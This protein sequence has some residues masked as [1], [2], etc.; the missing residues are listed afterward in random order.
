ML[1]LKS[2]G[3]YLPMC[4]F[5]IPYETVYVAVTVKMWMSFLS[6]MIL[7]LLCLHH[8]MCKNPSAKEFFFRITLC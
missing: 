6:L 5:G 8:G 2:P 3:I 7:L 1:H 4:S